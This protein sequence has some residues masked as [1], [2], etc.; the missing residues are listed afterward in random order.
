MHCS[1]EV[2]GP[3]VHPD[4]DAREFGVVRRRVRGLARRPVLRSPAWSVRS[5][6]VDK[7][8]GLLRSPTSH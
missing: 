7:E 1:G 4:A 5:F 2:G 3:Q 8:M 6:Y